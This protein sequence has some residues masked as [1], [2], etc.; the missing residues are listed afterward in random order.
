[1]WRKNRVTNKGSSCKGVD[2]NRN[3]G[4]HWAGKKERKKEITKDEIRRGT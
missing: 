2:L 1:M 4:F 3:W